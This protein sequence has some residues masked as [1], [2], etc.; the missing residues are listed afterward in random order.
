[1][2]GLK[3]EIYIST[4]YNNVQGKIVSTYPALLSEFQPFVIKL[5]NIM[6]Y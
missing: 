3:Y 2:T 6:L 4:L 1:M 5:I